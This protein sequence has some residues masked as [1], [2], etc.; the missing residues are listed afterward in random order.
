MVRRVQD[1][2][3]VFDERQPDRCPQ[4]TFPGPGRADQDQIG[5]LVQPAIA[6]DQGVDMGLGDHGH[7]IEVEVGERFAGRQF[8]FGE[9]AFEAPPSPVGDLLF[10]QRAEQAGRGPAFGIGAFGDL[11]PGGPEGRQA[12]LG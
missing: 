2:E 10:G 12:Q 5:A 11:R 8:G 7:D 1:P 4:V 6:G 9:M 3:A